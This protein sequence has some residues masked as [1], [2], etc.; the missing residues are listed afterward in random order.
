MQHKILIIDDSDVDRKIIEHILRRNFE[1]I[2]IYESKDGLGIGEI[3]KAHGIMMCVL[4]LRMPNVDGI[5][6]LKELKADKVTSDV[7]VIVCTGIL[8]VAIMERVLKL[9]AYDYFTKPFSEE[10]MK[11]SLPLK[12]KNSIELWKRTEHILLMSQ[13][14]GLTSIYNRRYFKDV[15]DTKVWEEQEFPI[16][17]MMCDINGLKVL[18]DAYGSCAGDIFLKK[19][20]QIIKLTL[21]ESAI[22][23][24]WGGDEFAALIPGVGLAEAKKIK[25]KINEKA[26]KVNYKGLVLNIAIGMDSMLTSSDTLLNTMKNAEDA[27][28]RNKILESESVRS[29]MIETILH[30]L[31]VKNPREEAH[32]RRVSELCVKMGIALEMNEEDIYELKIIGLLH[33]I[34]KIAIDEKVLNKPDKLTDA[35]YAEIKRHPEIGY[36]ILS[37]SKEMDPYL[38]IILAHHERFDGKGYPNGLSGSEIPL[39]ARILNVID[40]FDAMTCYRPYRSTKTIEDATRELIKCAGTQFDKHIVEVFVHRVVH[41]IE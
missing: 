39:M 11:F 24:R 41:Y 31:N 4:D 18:N 5:E 32:S 8:D 25:K 29:A 15:L 17:V 6:I 19:T 13:L 3:I 23:S 37:T 21:P 34:G 20:A 28:F 26:S 38:D 33:D 16:T 1:D 27:M 2:E 12:V 36:R 35:E 10:A 22:I 14:D 7:P 30:T 9:G 40:S